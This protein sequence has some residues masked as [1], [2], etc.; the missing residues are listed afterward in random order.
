M[1]DGK[2]NTAKQ[3][4]L[5][6]LPIQVF[7]PF[8]VFAAA[9]R[10]SSTWKSLLENDGE[11][12]VIVPLWGPHWHKVCLLQP[13]NCSR[14]PTLRRSKLPGRRVQHLSE[15][16]M[17]LSYRTTIFCF[18]FPLPPSNQPKGVALKERTY[19]DRYRF[20]GRLSST[21][22]QWAAEAV[23]SVENCERS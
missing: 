20:N 7:V 8:H 12:S 22:C 5:C 23:L 15:V 6:Y 16:Q 1:F 9:R 11:G 18:C 2:K 17:G 14:C 3:E 4:P 21:A 13:A 19:P 10:H